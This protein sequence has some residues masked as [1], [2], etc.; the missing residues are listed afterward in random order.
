MRGRKQAV[1]DSRP[2]QASAQ[3]RAQAA[4]LVQTE[5][6]A[7]FPELKWE[8]HGQRQ[9]VQQRKVQRGA[10]G[11]TIVSLEDTHWQLPV[12]EDTIRYKNQEIYPSPHIHLSAL[13][14]Y[15]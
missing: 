9:L 13:G 12:F 11:L 7:C 3:R 5:P 14:S 4:P 8:S 10:L 6:P 2:L 1:L 15:P